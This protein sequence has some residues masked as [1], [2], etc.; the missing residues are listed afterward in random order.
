MFSERR[1][2]GTVVN[3]S[4]YCLNFVNAGAQLISSCLYVIQTCSLTDT[5]PTQ[6]YLIA[7]MKRFIIIDVFDLQACLP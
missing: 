4:T 3:T 2:L 7:G 6:R 5:Q 1:S